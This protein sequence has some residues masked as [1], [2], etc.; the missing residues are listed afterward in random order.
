LKRE[1]KHFDGDVT[2]Q[3]NVVMENNAIKHGQYMGKKDLGCLI[4]K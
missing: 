3:I 1:E 2:N 4:L